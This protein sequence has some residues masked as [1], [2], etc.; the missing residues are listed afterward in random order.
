MY[1]P[2]F[3]LQNKMMLQY[4]NQKVKNLEYEIAD[5]KAENI[6]LTQYVYD[7]MQPDTPPEYKEVIRSKVFNK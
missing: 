7:L 3:N 2:F 6:E 1:A 5:I 4:Y